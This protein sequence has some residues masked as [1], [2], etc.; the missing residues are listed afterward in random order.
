MLDLYDKLTIRYEHEKQEAMKKII[1]A[2]TF[3]ACM[4][5]HA[6]TMGT[7]KPLPWEFG[8]GIG[9]VNYMGM[10][11]KNTTVQRLS[12]ARHLFDAHTMHVGV[13][14]GAQ[15]GL[16]SRL[17]VSQALYSSFGNTAIQTTIQ[18]FLDILGTVAIP[19]NFGQSLSSTLKNMPYHEKSARLFAA[20]DVVAKVGVAYRQMHFDRD[21][22]NSKVEISPEIQVGLR[23]SLSRSV[24][25]GLVYQGIY[26]SSRVGLTASST[27]PLI[28]TGAV[29]HIP[30]QNG[31]LL[32]LGW[33]A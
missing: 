29:K 19:L 2:S 23:K 7:E 25:I 31:G 20:T 14:V 26:S 8:V 1:L 10:V 21:T 16:S 4:H 17:L 13:E 32:F 18:P 22:I 3:L 24:S 5:A 30:T 6:G 28:A 27:N 15:T 11:D 9:Y 12:A 33:N